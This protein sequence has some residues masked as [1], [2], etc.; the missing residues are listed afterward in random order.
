MS[1]F[2]DYDNRFA[3]LEKKVAWFI[4][5]AITLTAI[6]LAGIVTKQQLFASTTSLYFY[7]GDASDLFEGMAVKMRGFNV[8][9]VQQVTMEPDAG[10]K[11]RVEIKNE[12]MR[13]IRKGSAFH[14]AGKSMFED[15][16][17][18][19][20]LAS[21]NNPEIESGAT[22]NL[23]REPGMGELAGK[24]VQQVEP[25]LAEVKHTIATIN[26]PN[27]DVRRLIGNVDK[28]VTKL[29]ESSEKFN[30][31]MKNSNALVVGEK[32]KIAKLLDN[33]NAV[34]ARINEALPGLLLKVDTTLHNV[35]S[36]SVDLKRLTAEASE[37]AVPLL[38]DGK[39]VMEDSRD[40]LGSARN[41]WPIRNMM[42]Q[43]AEKTLAPDSYV[44]K[45]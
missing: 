17:I 9:K 34:M 18:N 38:N 15:T 4:G 20:R 41:S 22:M 2:S 13:F 30:T 31:L 42:E 1:I 14:L 6:V 40:I 39:A 3:G 16:V 5:V 26:D 35:E 12:Y 43:P 19:I 23:V 32:E 8:G 28:T 36:A 33:S 10:I 21:I 44:P 27:G 25:V 29:G 11:V 37:S 24:L 7:T 45:K